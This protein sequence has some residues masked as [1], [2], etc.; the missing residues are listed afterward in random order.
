MYL[1]DYRKVI[2]WEIK[3]PLTKVKNP[4]II[5]CT[6]I[7]SL[8]FLSKWLERNF[9]KYNFRWSSG[10][11]VSYYRPQTMSSN[12][13]KLHMSSR[14]VISRSTEI[15][16]SMKITENSEWNKYWQLIYYLKFGRIL[17]ICILNPTPHPSPINAKLQ[18]ILMGH[19]SKKPCD[20]LYRKSVFSLVYKTMHK[21]AQLF[22]PSASKFFI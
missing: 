2:Y 4:L 11:Q 17:L 13:V 9:F 6:F 12:Q 16:L 8:F 21:S 19:H 15:C 20:A 5:I 22:K 18:C 10:G 7:F 3:K 1:W 14:K